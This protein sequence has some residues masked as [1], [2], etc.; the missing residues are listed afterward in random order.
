VAAIVIMGL[1][2]GATGLADSRPQV[3][4]GLQDVSVAAQEPGDEYG[5]EED[6]DAQDH[7]QC[8]H[9]IPPHRP[10]RRCCVADA[11]E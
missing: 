8:N 1:L 6:Y 2:G 7:C 4:E 10:E 9:S 11:S 3:V 5:Q